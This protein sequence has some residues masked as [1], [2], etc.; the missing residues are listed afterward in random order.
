[1]KKLK[2]GIIGCGRVAKKSHTEAI[3]ANQ[4]LIDCTYACDLVEE[5]A[6]EFALMIASNTRVNPNIT[7]NYKELLFD[8]N[9][10]AIVIATE[11]DKHFKIVMDTLE[12]GKHVLVEKPIA[13]STEHLSIMINK[14]HEKKMKLAVCH[15]NRFNPPIQEVRK[16]IESGD[17]GKILYGTIQIRW[18]RNENYYKQASWRGTWEMDGGALMNQSIH[19]IDLLQWMLGGNVEEVYGVISNMRHPYIEAED[20]GTAILKF[21][22][23]VIGIIEATTNIYPKNLEEKLS[24]FGEKGTVIIGGLAVNRIETWN[25]PNESSHPFMNL[26]DPET[27]YGHSHIAIYRDFAESIINDKEPYINGEE[28]RKAVDIVLAIYKSFKEKRA[29]R[30]SNLDWS[31]KAMISIFENK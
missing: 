20:F 14:A 30:I 29:V 31:T 9:L 8:P 18:S 15:Q 25:F 17:F 10:D 4:D 13:L 11:S 22:N 16:K 23:G 1:M 7:N 3:I 19:G 24:I 28:G 5:N 27:V 6:R 12:V 21:K 26:S 2:I